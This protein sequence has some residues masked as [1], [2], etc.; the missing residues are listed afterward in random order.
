MIDLAVFVLLTTIDNR[1]VYI[2]PSQVVSISETR[3][4][5]SSD[6][7][8]TPKVHCALTLANGKLVTVGDDC[9]TV[10]RKFKEENA[11]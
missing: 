1:H 4:E 8:L 7:L 9:E 10:M 6:R 3:D 2:N 5:K 11:K